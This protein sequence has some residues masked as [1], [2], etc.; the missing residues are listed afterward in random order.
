MFPV[1]VRFLLQLERSDRDRQR[2]TKRG[3][4]RTG[5]SFTVGVDEDE[6]GRKG[7]NLNDC[8]VPEGAGLKAE[9]PIEENP[10][11]GPSGT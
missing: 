10:S 6:S 3:R 7:D 8:L 1:V 9:M 2:A 4:G 5:T 11:Q